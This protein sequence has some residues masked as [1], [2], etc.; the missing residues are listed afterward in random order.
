MRDFF[1]KI[2][3]E[4]PHYSF[5]SG[6]FLGHEPMTYFFS[7]VLSRG[8]YPEASYDSENI[9]FMT[10]EEHATWEFKR[11]KIVDDPMWTKVFSLKEALIQKHQKNLQIIEQKSDNVID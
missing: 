2:W 4:R 11:H 9:V 10:L 1:I 3:R 6:K 5:V 7:H 8:A